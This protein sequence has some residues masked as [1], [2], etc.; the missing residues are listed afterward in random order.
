[1]L[2]PEKIQVLPKVSH[3]MLG[4]SLPNPEQLPLGVTLHVVVH[5]RTNTHYTKIVTLSN[6]E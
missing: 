3:N 5:N 4:F 6:K 1:M 2:T